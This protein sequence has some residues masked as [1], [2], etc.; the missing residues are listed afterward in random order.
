MKNLQLLLLVFLC[1]FFIGLRT[2]YYVN[3]F[4]NAPQKLTNQLM[5]IQTDSVKVDGNFLKLTGNLQGK[6]YLVYH[7][8]KTPEEKSIWVGKELPN[9]ALVSG[10]TEAFDVARNLNGFDARKYY[11]SLGYNQIL[12]IESLKTLKKQKFSLNDLRQQ[13][14]WKID[15]RYSRRLSSYIKALVIGY[16]DAHFEE[17]TAAYKTTG[18]LH[19]FTLSGLHIQ[20]Y[21]GGVHLLLKRIGL[22]RETRLVILSMIGVLLTY[23]TGGSYSTIRAVFSFLIA[24]ACLTFELSFSKLDQWS[25]MLFLVVLLFPL[26]FWSVG[27]QLS[28]YFALLLLYLNDFHFKI[29]QQMFLFSV[30]SLPVLLYSFSEWTIIGGLFTLLLFPLF[31]WVILPGCLL[32]FMGCFFP[33]PHFLSKILDSIFHIL[34]KALDLVAFPN[35]TIGRPSFLILLVLLILVLWGI[36]RLKYREKVLWLVGGAV[37][38]LLSI[39]FS[40]KGMIAFV[41]VGQG[42]SIFI[43][44]PFKQET[45]LIDTGGRLNFKQKEGQMRQQ[46]QLS[47]YNL[48]PFLKSLGCTQIDHLIVT[49]NDADHMGELT[50]LLNELKVKNLYLAKGS[51]MELRSILQPLKGTKIH[52]TK[53]GE[54]IGKKLKL[55]VLSPEVSEG[56]NDD[57]LVTYFTLNHQRFLLTGDLEVAG[58]EKLLK[59]YPQLKA[60]FLKIGHHGSNTSTGEQFIKQLRPKYGVI[61]VGRRNRYGHPTTETLAKLKKYR[62]NVLRTDQQ[63]MIYYQ[64]SA[65]T[66]KGEIKVLIDFLDQS[67]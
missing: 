39:S 23:L 37:V 42:D 2:Y 59:K 26:V 53:R 20:F 12:Q 45:F 50:H 33:I 21:L 62:V 60:D 8:L 4:D 13:L 36:D 58:E 66:K 51:Q 52:L 49:H 56:E 47:D 54:M 35:L 25:L 43:K 17:Y 1:S 48:L 10:E 22:T 31:E 7:T 30:L 32:L 61:S 14:I 15:Q 28:L 38:L 27:A 34:E 6:K 29:H 41:D 18:L 40:A 65:F 5:Q 67:W 46:K 44:L 24:F 57:S 64:W 3:Q 16:K 11:R 63:G 19:L 55:Q 9:S